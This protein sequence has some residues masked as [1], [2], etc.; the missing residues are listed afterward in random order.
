MP[1]AH[2]PVAGLAADVCDHCDAPSHVDLAPD[3][4]S[5]RFTGKQKGRD[6]KK[7]AAVSRRDAER[8]PLNPGPAGQTTKYTKNEQLTKAA[9]GLRCFRWNNMRS[10]SWA[11]G[12]SWE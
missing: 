1:T 5:N 2:H 8:D 11:T 7:G 3:S 4:I 12:E 9:A 10:P 6:N